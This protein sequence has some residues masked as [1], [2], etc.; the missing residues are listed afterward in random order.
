MADP[1]KHISWSLIVSGTAL[2]FGL[3]LLFPPG[4]GLSLFEQVERRIPGGAVL[5]LGLA[6]YHLRPWK[7]L[8]PFM[9]SLFCGLTAGA[10]TGRLI[11]LAFIGFDSE[12]QWMWVAI[13]GVGLVLSVLFLR[14]RPRVK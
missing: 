14:K 8:A 12:K 13:E 10:L 7:P 3:D 9:A 5:G 2:I 1:R 4:E 11:G 6:I